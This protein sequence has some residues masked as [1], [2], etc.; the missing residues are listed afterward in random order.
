MAMTVTT[1]QAVV[2]ANV[3]QAVTGLRTVQTEARAL[4]PAFGSAASATNALHAAVGR[5]PAVFGGMAGG[6]GGVLAQARILPGPIGAV[7]SSFGM[8]TAAAGTLG[9][10][11]GAVTVVILAAKAAW[12]FLHSTLSSAKQELSIIAQTNGVLASTK[13]IAGQTAESIQALADSMTDLVGVD[14][15][16]SRSVENML[17]TFT[18][19]R[20]EAFER[21]TEA[22]LNMAAA[23]NNGLVPTLEQ[24]QAFSIQVGKALNDPI[25]G[26]TALHRVGV[27]F[28]EQ[29]KLLIAK[30]MEHG[31]MAKAQK[32]ILDELA[33]EFGRAGAA[34][35]N[36]FGGQLGKLSKAWDDIKENIGERIL[37]LFADVMKRIAPLVILVGERLP[38][39][40][41]SMQNAVGPVIR[42]VRDLWDQLSRNEQVQ[43]AF[44][45]FSEVLG[46][47]A[48]PMALV[49]SVAGALILALQAAPVLAIVGALV[50]LANVAAIVWERAKPVRDVL[51]FI[52]GLMF[53]VAGAI[54]SNLGP[55]FNWLGDR[56][57]DARKNAGIMAGAL[58]S[59]FTALA[60]GIRAQFA[61]I[62]T[63]ISFAINS[64]IDAI[65]VFL[66]GV[67][68]IQIDIP[69]VGHVGVNVPLL[70]H[71]DLGAIAG[72]AGAALGNMSQQ[73]LNNISAL[74]KTGGKSEKNGSSGLLS[75]SASD[76]TDAV[77]AGTE[78][79]VKKAAADAKAHT[80]NIRVASDESIDL[81]QQI[82]AE[83]YW[84][85]AIRN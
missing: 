58:M 57:S 44:R 7:A 29:Q 53:F 24:T 26:I 56:F 60:R 71:V 41:D 25:L 64:V 36:T 81:A 42:T 46:K 22:V 11:L 84:Q 62:A 30:Y 37:P 43:A 31:Q 16:V 78:K 5:A 45:T 74:F 8:L 10:A 49:A 17:L 21:G 48:G 72:A 39:A 47:I 52:G 3:S 65:N 19:I 66:R 67:N 54:F 35:G 13:G 32:V 34:A 1:L 61:A 38:G 27:A 69:G 63:G 51:Q 59:G 73:G 70:G 80:Y 15:D 82:A 85:Q 14:D 83:I 28:T 40:L 12:D 4:G 33:T 20:G 75:L 6:F 76:L 79:G 77:A 68:A 55:A 18:N 2:T 50:G 23:Y 9:V